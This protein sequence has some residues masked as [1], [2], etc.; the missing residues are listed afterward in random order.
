MNSS[1]ENLKANKLFY[2]RASNAG[3]GEALS[4][5]KFFTMQQTRNLLPILFFAALLSLVSACKPEKATNW[6]HNDNTVRVRQVVEIKTLNPYLYRFVYEANVFSLIFQYLIDFDMA[7]LEMSPQLVKSRPVVQDITSGEFAGG[8][9]FAF[10][11][12]DEAVWEDGKPV[13]GHDFDFSLRVMFNPKLPLQR[14]ASYLDYVRDVQVDAANPKKFTVFTNRKYFLAEQAV[15]NVTVLPAHIYDNEGLMSAFPLKDLTDPA[16]VAAL[17]SDPKLQQFADAFMSPKFGRETVT[18]S[19]PYKLVEWVDGQRVVLAKKQNW[20]GDKLASKYP[21]LA[22]YPDSIVFL[23]IPDQTAAVA[24]LKDE[25][26]DV[27]LDIDAKQFN[28]MKNDP[29]AMGAFNLHTSPRLALFYNAFNTKN[30]KLSDKRVRQALAR[31]I[32]M[33]LVIKDL[34]DNMGERVVGPFTPDKKY[35]NKALKPIAFNLDE[36]RRLLDE[37]G[38]KDSNGDGVLDKTLDGKL[39]DLK[40]ECLY[41]PNSILQ[42]NLSELWQS[43]AQKVGIAMERVQAEGN[44]LREK[45]GARNYEIS[46]GLGASVPPV[47]D[48]PKQFF[49]TDSDTPGGSN[50]TRFGN[51]ETDALIESIRNAP[52]EATRNPLYIRL[53]EILYDEQPMVFMFSPMERIAVHKRFSN[54]VTGRKSPN[55]SLQHLK[56]EK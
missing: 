30:P 42:N 4:G 52:D 5:S 31:L 1:D 17:A 23:P 56:L 34:Y 2:F 9:S 25:T 10:E 27:G 16:K 7:T 40:L 24:A 28:E 3:T 48:D 32:D 53:Q 44:V 46:I 13:T 14:F 11:I 29:V 20:W 15:S 21:S 39:T 38:W 6:K 22:A 54:V 55:I 37:A 45:M 19:G 33:D 51:A 41:N 35:Y 49:H 43:N 26:I 50:Y 8:Q 36:A 47:P 18:G 12:L